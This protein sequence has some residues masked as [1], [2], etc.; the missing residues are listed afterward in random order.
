MDKFQLVSARDQF[1]GLTE[2]MQFCTY[3]KKIY[4]CYLNE[5]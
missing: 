3:V 1:I 4:L 2:I 5:S